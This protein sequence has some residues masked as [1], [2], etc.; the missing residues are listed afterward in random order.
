MKYS[1]NGTKEMH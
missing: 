1:Y